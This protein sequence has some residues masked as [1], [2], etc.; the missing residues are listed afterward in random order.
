M[1][2]QYKDNIMRIFANTES[3]IIRFMLYGTAV[4]VD[5]GKS[6]C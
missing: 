5:R 1:V 2:T 6:E 4:F 3:Y